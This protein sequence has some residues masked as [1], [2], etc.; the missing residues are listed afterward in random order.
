MYR[1]KCRLIVVGS[2]LLS[3]ILSVSEAQI[4]GSGTANYIP[5]FTGSTS[6]GNSAI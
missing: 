5:K 3:A 1:E 6:I 2:V 4:T